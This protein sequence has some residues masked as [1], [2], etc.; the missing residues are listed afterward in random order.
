MGPRPARLRRS[1]EPSEALELDEWVLTS[2]GTHTNQLRHATCLCLERLLSSA[3]G[4]CWNLEIGDGSYSPYRRRVH[5]DRWNGG[6]V[7]PDIYHL[8]SRKLDGVNGWRAAR[9]GGVVVAGPPHL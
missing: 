4:Y 5:M 9:A 6:N 8:N 1:K 3:T 2:K 7:I